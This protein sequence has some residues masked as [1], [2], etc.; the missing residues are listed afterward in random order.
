MM[1]SDLSCNAG[2]FQQAMFPVT[3]DQLTCSDCEGAK[4]K[5][6]HSTV[7]PDEGMQ[8]ASSVRI[9]IS[10][11]PMLEGNGSSSKE[12][13]GTELDTVQH[14]LIISILFLSICSSC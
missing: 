5:L 4:S 13:Y 7:A 1:C 2:G 14:L 8:H 12:L 6:P 9:S 11:A 10:S 3:A